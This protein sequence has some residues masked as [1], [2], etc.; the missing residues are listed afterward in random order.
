MN[1]TPTRPGELNFLKLLAVPLRVLF[2]L[3]S[4]SSA[5]AAT[6]E[7]WGNN[8]ELWNPASSILKDFTDAGYMEGE[9]PIPDWPV[10]VNVM[11]YGAIPNDG[12]DDSQA[13]MAAL[14][15]CDEN[16]AVLVP[17]GEFWIE[18][19]IVMERDNIVLRGADTFDTVVF[20]PKY[21]NEAHLIKIDHDPALGDRRSTQSELE[22]AFFVLAGQ[23]QGIEQMSF[24]FRDQVKL[25]HWE[26]L[27]GNA[28]IANGQNQ[29]V[30]DVYFKNGDH[31]LITNGRNNSFLNLI[32]DQ[33]VGRADGAGSV[34]HMGINM[35]NTN[36]NLYHNI[37]MTQRWIHPFDIKSASFN[38]ISDA[39]AFYEPIEYHGQGAQ[40][41]LYTNIE[42]I[43]PRGTN[44]LGSGNNQGH[45]GDTFW[46]VFSE[47]GFLR[48]VDVED[49]Y[50]T[51]NNRG[52][53]LV[54]YDVDP[55]ILPTRTDSNI[56][57]E[58]IDPD[59]LTPRN[60]YL[61][62]MALR[63]KPLPASPPLSPPAIAGDLIQLASS[64]TSIHFNDVKD[65]PQAQKFDLN[66]L[67]IDSIHKARLRVV[68]LRKGG[69]ASSA[70]VPTTF[71]VFS[72][73]DDS[74]SVDDTSTFPPAS[75]ELLDT[76]KVL[77]EPLFYTIEF[78]VTDFVQS[79]WL[80]DK[81][82]S[83]YPA[84]IE[85][86]DTIIVKGL[87]GFAP[88]LIIEQVP[89]S[90]P[91]R[92]TAPEGLHSTGE[93]GNV[94]LDWED[95]PESDVV[96]YNVYRRVIEGGNSDPYM[97]DFT[98]FLK[99]QPIG[100]G[101]KRSEFA[102]INFAG[103]WQ[104]G[105]TP[106][107][108]VSLYRVTAVDAHGYESPVSHI[109]VGTT[110]TAL[111]QPPVATN[112]LVQL[113][114]IEE[115]IE[116]TA[117]VSAMA[118][119]PEGNTLYFSKMNGPDW[120]TVDL[121]GT[122]YLAPQIGDTGLH[123]FSVQVNATG[124]R[125]EMQVQ[126]RVA[127]AE[128]VPGAPAIPQGLSALSGA[129]IVMLEWEANLE[130]DLWGYTLYRSTQ[131]GEV[132]I[133]VASGLSETQFVDTDVVD[134]SSY[135]YTLLAEDFT[136]QVS[137][138]SAQVLA[139]PSPEKT[140]DMAVYSFDDRATTSFDTDADSVASELITGAGIIFRPNNWGIPSNSR[141]LGLRQNEGGMFGSK[142]ASFTLSQLTEA[143]AL[144]S[145]RFSLESPPDNLELRL[146]SSQNGFTDPQSAIP[147]DYEWVKDDLGVHFTFWLYRLPSLPAND[148]EFRLYLDYTRGRFFIDNIRFAKVVDVP[149][150]PFA[151]AT[152]MGL[153]ATAGN[154][155][156]SLDWDDYPLPGLNSYS[157]YRSA[158]ADASDFGVLIASGLTE[159]QFA[160]DDVTVGQSYYYTVAAVNG[161]GATSQKSAQLE[162]RA[163]GS[164]PVFARSEFELHNA[165]VGQAYQLNL[166]AWTLGE[167]PAQWNYSILSGPSWLSVD[168]QGILSGQPSLSDIG[169]NE[170]T[171][172]ID[173]GA[174]ST[175]TA[176][177]IIGVSFFDDSDADG[178]EDN[179][180]RLYVGDISQGA[181]DD[182][183][184]DGRNNLEEFQS[185]TDPAI[186]NSPDSSGT[187]DS[188]GDGMS[189]VDEQLA[190]SDPNDPNSFWRTQ[191][192]TASDENRIAFQFPTVPG[193][194]YRVFYRDSLV[195]GD[196]QTMAG[197]ENLIGDG[198][199]LTT[200]RDARFY[201]VRVQA[202]QW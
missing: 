166:D 46:G 124:G 10:D 112:T 200:N 20:F 38:V 18:Q 153:M 190:G 15:A 135:H 106:Y 108:S 28:I 175:H 138:R 148:V 71:G 197:F 170:W 168:S 31:P 182:P 128:T 133:V 4:F 155:E 119:D 60:L 69:P 3:F 30:R 162:A 105:M 12:R 96:T 9:V 26:H 29:W 51:A 180:E 150:I 97:G 126:V 163:Y 75:H 164:S 161:E 139:T 132:G 186:P 202:A 102:D 193:R 195:S 94:L 171:I 92:P 120:I 22:P 67:D 198:N 152:P 35:N 131:P 181:L 5:H 57:F 114:D 11:D 179:W 151:A 116:G 199:P 104:I 6:S 53:I 160:D 129:G 146:F 14:A 99:D 187:H 79:Q 107:N 39:K 137:L 101:L 192:I 50:F 167:N 191:L 127:S 27:G 8:G 2:F 121:D 72:V 48:S 70:F 85:G 95:S 40:N 142:Y 134:G 177:F 172:Q 93:V 117:N 58:S 23:H 183:D 158:Q 165:Y 147:V 64:E 145:L 115:R 189:N 19:Q 52:Y 25:G 33:F 185:G 176:G 13:F 47:K 110:I 41:N 88:R 32:F 1:N 143:V 98:E 188:D 156:I 141:A 55:A 86:N 80:G 59:V 81:V 42:T 83:L 21:T 109:T 154:G 87:S 201:Q 125:D 103:D 82:V 136:G 17:A 173:R 123:T 100:M 43:E 90:V 65:N 36:F 61:A 130:A 149:A 169:R 49:P 122:I 111:S 178:L 66:G 63:N 194:Y 24:V 54:G 113:D 78:D 34:G 196:W 56:W 144:Q 73:L 74:W 44:G 91:G 118:S 7:L 62:Q 37:L 174:G 84:S 157:V 45:F 77:E 89:S 140:V 16:H 184:G 76:V 159:S 68:L